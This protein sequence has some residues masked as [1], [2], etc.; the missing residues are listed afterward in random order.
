M[1]TSHQ[2]ATQ[3]VNPSDVST[4]L[5]VLGGDVVQKAFSQATGTLYVPVC[6]SFGCVAYAFVALVGIIGD[7]RL[8]APPDYPCKVLNLK[9]GYLRENKNFVLGRLLRDLEAI[10]TR[11]ENLPS[12]GGSDEGGNYG[13]KITVFEATWNKNDR[14]EF[15]WS[16]V[17]AVG[18]VITI[19]QLVLAFIPFIVHRTWSVLLITGA[20]TLLVQWIGLL[21]QWRAEKLPNRQ[22]SEQV[23]A[24]TSGNGS[25]EVMVIFGCGNCL[26]IESL[27]ASQ[28]PR[29][30]RP[31]EKF[32]WLSRPQEGRD[33][34][35]PI[36]RRNTMLRKAKRSDVWMFRGY[37]IGFIITEVSCVCLSVLWLLLLVNVSARS[38]FPESWCLLGV[39]ALGMFQNA[40]LAARELT[41]EMRNLPLNRVDQVK[42]RKV[43]DCIMDFHAT[44]KL[45]LPLKDEFFPGKLKED[46]EAWWGG[47][48]RQYN[49]RRMED[50][51]RGEP[52]QMAHNFDQKLGFL[53]ETFSGAD[54]TLIPIPE[55]SEKQKTA[56]T[57][58][59]APGGGET[60]AES[61]EFMAPRPL[62]RAPT[63]EMRSGS[64]APPVWLA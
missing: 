16:W 57:H 26:D 14:T 35:F 3:W 23:Y 54:A 13:L 5:F 33:R 28:S 18:V 44:Y 42:S 39:G 61:S 19:I 52:R 59:T 58:Q 2:L 6:F 17:H 4:I 27:A 22:R 12:E 41:P 24:M 11:E 45:G 53:G 7:G 30:G 1:S 55:V 37:P 43:M 10:E 21:P 31:W 29:N 32:L 25:R 49:E 8:L 34:D 36:A 64:K 40:W 56:R 62:P 50:L 20:G 60:A 48:R 46:E 9:S 47:D 51:T 38:E 63:L 15:S